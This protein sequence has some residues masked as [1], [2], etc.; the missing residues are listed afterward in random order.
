MFFWGGP[1]LCGNPVTGRFLKSSEA[2]PFTSAVGATLSL[3]GL[4]L[5]ES[6]HLDS[7]KKNIM[8]YHDVNIIKVMDVRCLLLVKLSVS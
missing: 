5:S 8:R 1:L 3:A 2:H 6:S 4:G 7:G